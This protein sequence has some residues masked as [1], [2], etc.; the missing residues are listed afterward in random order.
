MR[1]LQARCILIIVF[2]IGRLFVSCQKISLELSQL[3]EN[4]QS[5]LNELEISEYA[6]ILADHQK[7]RKYENQ[8]HWDRPLYFNKEV[9]YNFALPIM[10]RQC[11]DDAIFTNNKPLQSFS[12]L[13]LSDLLKMEADHEII[14]NNMLNEFYQHLPAIY[15]VVNK[16]VEAEKHLP[17]WVQKQLDKNPNKVEISE[18]LESIAR[19]SIAFD[20]DNMAGMVKDTTFIN[21]YPYWN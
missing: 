7:I 17:S 2:I 1:F 8:Y 6:Y 21:H 16:P 20:R 14:R 13:T 18:L 3:E 4:I 11:M 15:T 19:L 9:L 12:Y 5:S 10:I